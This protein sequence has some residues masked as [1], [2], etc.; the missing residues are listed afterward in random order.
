M[1]HVGQMITKFPQKAKP[2]SSITEFSGCNG[3]KCGKHFYP[4]AL[5]THMSP[6]G[7]GPHG[8]HQLSST[9]PGGYSAWC[10]PPKHRANPITQL[11]A[12]E[13]FPSIFP[14]DRER[15]YTHI[16]ATLEKEDMQPYLDGWEEGPV[17][18]VKAKQCLSSFRMEKSVFRSQAD[19]TTKE[20][21]AQNVH[22]SFKVK[23]IV[24]PQKSTD[25]VKSEAKYFHYLGWM[26]W[27]FPPTLTKQ[28]KFAS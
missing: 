8:Q 26:S 7:L 23:T 10:C 5:F 17:L 22:K 6:R 9:L 15:L 21:L 1:E 24:Y 16:A 11:W 19:K 4:K 14:G 13:I 20:K 25:N 2:L 3:N 28:R 27:H 12:W 18:S